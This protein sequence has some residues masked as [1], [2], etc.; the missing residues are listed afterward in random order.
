[1]FERKHDQPHGDEDVHAG[2]DFQISP[3]ASEFMSPR[4][5]Q[6]I[7]TY[8]ERNKEHYVIPK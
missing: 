3:S 8:L 5:N 4:H 6:N 2:I 7:V 1:M